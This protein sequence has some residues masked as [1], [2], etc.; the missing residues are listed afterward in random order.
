MN[1]TVQSIA[2]HL[3]L[4]KSTVSMALRNNPTVSIK[5]RQRIQDAARGMNY[6]PN[7]IAQAMST[8]RANVIGF[9]THGIASEYHAIFIDGLS[10]KADELGYL[11]KIIRVQWDFDAKALVAKCQSQCLSGLVC[12]EASESSVKELVELAAGIGLPVSQIPGN[13]SL[14][15]LISICCDDHLGIH[16]A[17]EHLV[18]LGHKR[19][20]FIGGDP[21]TTSAKNREVGYR[22]AIESQGLK[23]NSQD[24]CSGDY[25][26]A[27]SQS[28]TQAILSQKNR[29]TALICANDMMAMVVIRTARSMGIQTPG[30]ISVVGFSD[31]HMAELCDPPLTSIRQPQREMGQLAIEHVVSAIKYRLNQVKPASEI[32]VNE[33][34]E[35]QLIIRESTSRVLV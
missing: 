8:G 1:P 7:A 15:K 21:K 28:A 10:E 6:F 33:N 12:G 34:L 17:V 35:T 5:T 31:L 4:A 30:D 9:A 16:Q 13:P 19:I 18:S 3:G 14:P 32:P 25:L 2:D 24:I 26:A 29:P 11:V 20:G 27:S 22:K 23:I